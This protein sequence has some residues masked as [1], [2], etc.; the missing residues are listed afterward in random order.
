[1]KKS[2]Q[3][4]LCCITT[5]S[6]TELRLLELVV[7]NPGIFLGDLGFLFWGNRKRGYQGRTMPTLNR[8]EAN[9]LVEVTHTRCVK[10]DNLQ[11]QYSATEKAHEVLNSNTIIL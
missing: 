2:Q 7:R 9:S 5:L 10:T 1:M 11:K 6:P 4:K 8:L 3:L